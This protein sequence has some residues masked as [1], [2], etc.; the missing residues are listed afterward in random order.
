MIGRA[1]YQT[2][3]SGTAVAALRQAADKGDSDVAPMAAYKLGV[4]LKEQGDVEG[5]K[6]AF[7]RAAGSGYRPP[8]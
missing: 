7:Y 6:A 8:R 1:A 4:L 5:A 2:K 3:N